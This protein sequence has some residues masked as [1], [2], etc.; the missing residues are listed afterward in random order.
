MSIQTAVLCA[1]SKAEHNR[2]AAC[3][4]MQGSSIWLVGSCALL[5]GPQTTH[6]CVLTLLRPEWCYGFDGG[7]F[8]LTSATWGYPHTGV[9]RWKSEERAREKKKRKQRYEGNK[10]L[11]WLW[12]AHIFISS[13]VC[14]WLKSCSFRSGSLYIYQLWLKSSR[15]PKSAHERLLM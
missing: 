14:I 7:L 11:V 4:A 6:C 12:L 2:V 1:S 13:M 3:V 15:L 8:N 5:L 9:K 10:S